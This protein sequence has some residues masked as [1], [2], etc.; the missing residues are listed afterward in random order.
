MGYL[1]GEPSAWCQLCQ[2]RTLEDVRHVLGWCDSE[3]YRAIRSHWYEEVKREAWELSPALWKAI[4]AGLRC[5]DGALIAVGVKTVGAWHA[6]TGKIPILWTEAAM[7]AGVGRS[8]YEKWLRWYGK[9]IRNGLWWPLLKARR[10]QRADLADANGGDN[11]A[12]A[13]SEDSAGEDDD[14]ELEMEG[15]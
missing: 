9:E 15:A 10:L 4:E 12:A 11:G 2:Y 8:A 14:L 7:G 6:A 13:G 5:R 3:P 1:S